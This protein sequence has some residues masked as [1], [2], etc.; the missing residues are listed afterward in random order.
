MI[1]FFIDKFQNVKK[2]FF[3]L[4]SLGFKYNGVNPFLQS[5]IY[6]SFCILRI[7]Y[8]F[9]IITINKKTLKKLNI[10]QNDLVRYM[11]GLSRN[12]HISEILK[13]LKLFN[14]NEL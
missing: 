12:S 8:G 1:E 13:I 4:N 2:S 14:I 5:F 10:S 3:S 11:T 7:L 9:K 6:K